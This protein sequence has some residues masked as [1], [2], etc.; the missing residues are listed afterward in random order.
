M[1][2][3]NKNIQIERYM[4]DA[5]ADFDRI[6]EAGERR[7]QRAI[8]RWT[9]LSGLAVAACAAI[10]FWLAPMRSASVKQLTPIQIA[11]GIE[12]MMLLDI[13]EIESI[14]ATPEDSHAI[15]TAHLKDGSTCTFILRF[16]DKEGT[17]TLLAYNTI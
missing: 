6:L 7:R 8:V 12:Q 4:E 11:E 14:T 17:T 3:D 2:D 15:L 13:G 10:L 5:E 16:D 1:F 9:A